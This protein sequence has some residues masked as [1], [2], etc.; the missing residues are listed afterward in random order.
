MKQA[1]IAVPPAIAVV[2]LALAILAGSGATVAQQPVRIPLHHP[3]LTEGLTLVAGNS[4]FPADCNGQ[5]DGA[6]F[7]N[8]VVEPSV[9]SDPQN[10]SHLVGVWQQDC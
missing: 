3:V 9:A 10:P 2:V 7:R 5:Q 4:T 8:S 1:R 6:N